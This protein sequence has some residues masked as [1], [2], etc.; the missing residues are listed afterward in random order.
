MFNRSLFKQS[1]KAHGVMWAIITFAV[2]FMLACVMLIAGSSTISETKNAIQNTIIEDEL[3]SQVKKRSV[4]YYTTSDLGLKQFDES[5]TLTALSELNSQEMK[6][7]YNEQYEKYIAEGKSEADAKELADKDKLLKVGIK[8]YATALVETLDYVKDVIVEREIMT[9]EEVDEV[10]P[11]INLD[12]INIEDFNFKDINVEEIIDKLHPEALAIFGSVFF[13]LNP[14]VPNENLDGVVYLFD[15]FYKLNNEEAPRYDYLGALQYLSE[16]RIKYRKQYAFDNSLIFLAGNLI[17]KENIDRA[18]GDLVR[19]GVTFETFKKF[20]F[21]NYDYVKSIAIGSANDFRSN[22]N[23]R[24]SVKEEGETEES[25]IKDLTKDITQSLLTM[26]PPEVSQALDEVG[27]MDLYGT[28]VGSV[29]YK[30][31]GLLL[32]IIFV[33]MTGNALIAGQVDSGS[34]A[35]ILSSGVK[36]RTVVATQALYLIISLFAMFSC[37]TI[38]SLVCRAIVHVN[39]HL[40]YGKLLLLNFGAFMVMFAMAGICF[41]ASCLFNRSKRSMAIGGGLNMFFLVATMLGLFGSEIMPSIVR[42][43]S[44]NFFNYVSIISL[45]DVTNMLSGNL[46][47]L[48]KLLGLLVIGAVC[49]SIGSVRFIKKDLPL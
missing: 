1:C 6:D 14:M 41:L 29:F 36:R 11:S 38:T 47:F 10:I 20:G 7:Y 23:Y 48:W 42:M 25:I 31:A 27:Q 13:V 40:G 2:C 26:L 22:Y 30:M 33:I 5:L 8:S 32:P 12:E 49:F 46:I 19:Y 39:S 15:D 18:L 35:Y 44:L 28:L 34:M 43:D 4:N 17:R 9:R 45:F 21:A 24:M 3:T 16:D 37:T